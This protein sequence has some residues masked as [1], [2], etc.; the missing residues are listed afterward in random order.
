[1]FDPSVHGWICPVAGFRSR[2]AAQICASFANWNNGSMEKLK[3]IKLVYLSERKH[4]ARYHQPMLFDELYSLPLGPICSNTLEGINGLTHD[5]LWSR[6]IDRRGKLVFATDS[7]S[8]ASL[9]EISDAEFDILSEV[10][11]QFR[12][13]S[14]SQL[15][16]YCRECCPEYRETGGFRVPI[17]YEQIVGAIG[18]DC[19]SEIVNNIHAM[20]EF[21]R[22]LAEQ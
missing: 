22:M 13:Y 12:D 2:K 15:R 7:F 19:A 8:R 6:F 1:M 16:E 3:L 18:T 17:S 20:I 21:E 14:D 10:W 9:D 11:A 4:L 5:E